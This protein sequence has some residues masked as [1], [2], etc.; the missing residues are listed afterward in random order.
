ME[1]GDQQ[2]KQNDQNDGN[3]F[4]VEALFNFYLRYGYEPHVKTC[5]E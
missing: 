1:L 5:I 2:V 4:S 3:H